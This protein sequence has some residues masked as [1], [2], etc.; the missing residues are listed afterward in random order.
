[1]KKFLLLTLMLALTVLAFTACSDT[2]SAPEGMQLVYESKSEGYVF[3]GPE[4]WI[5]ANR[6]GVAA[7][8]LSS[9]NQTSITFTSA[10]MPAPDADS[11]AVDFNAYFDASIASFPYEVTKVEIGATDNFGASDAPADKAYRYVYTY[12]YGELALNA[13]ISMENLK[14]ERVYT[15]NNGGSNDGAISLTCSS[16]GKTITV[17]TALLKDEN[18]NI[19][20]E[21]YFVGKTINVKGV[22]DE[23]NGEYQ[24]KVFALGNITI[25]Q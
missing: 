14:V 12:K 15:T 11:G 21:D 10:Q 7:T 6:A 4:G 3:Y 8:Y 19:V 20:T 22:I 25:V 16:G 5:V 23:Y 24:I 1:M 13:S 17:R 18:G 9:F 2:G